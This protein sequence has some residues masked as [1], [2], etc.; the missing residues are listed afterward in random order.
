MAF[1]VHAMAA[2]TEH[3]DGLLRF[4]H[5]CRDNELVYR[6][7]YPGERNGQLELVQR[8]S[9]L[10]HAY[11]AAFGFATKEGLGLTIEEVS[12]DGKVTILQTEPPLLS[13]RFT[14]WL[15][16]TGT[17]FS[18]RALKPTPPTWRPTV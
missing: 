4:Y 17:G 18:L 5:A 16:P 10:W 3:L 8:G 6:C 1:T 13:A 9:P 7:R 15:Q 2:L 11:A 12:S 14:V